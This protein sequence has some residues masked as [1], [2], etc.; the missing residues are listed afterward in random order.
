M[1]NTLFCLPLFHTMVQ[2]IFQVVAISL[3]LFVPVGDWLSVH[4]GSVRTGGQQ[5]GAARSGYAA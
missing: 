3:F 1:P 5:E 2:I 4:D